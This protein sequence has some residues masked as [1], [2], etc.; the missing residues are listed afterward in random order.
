[1]GNHYSL[2]TIVTGNNALMERQAVDKILACNA[3]SEK[4]GLV[5]SEQQ[6]LALTR[7]QTNVLNET[8]RIEFNGG[9]VDKMISAF[10]DSPYITADNYEDTLHELISLFYELK[11]NTWDKISDQALITFMKNEFNSHCHGSLDM[12]AG[13]GFRLAEHIHCGKSLKTFQMEEQHNENT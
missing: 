6:A 5:L 13:E 2:L 9:I 10:C 4:Y 7:T 8:K 11:N 3:E 12:L 1:M